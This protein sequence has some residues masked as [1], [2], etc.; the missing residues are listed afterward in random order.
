MTQEE[1]L[2]T[3]SKEKRSLLFSVSKLTSRQGSISNFRWDVKK[4]YE[5]KGKGDQ[6]LRR[7]SLSCKRSGKQEEK[8]EKQEAK[9]KA[10]RPSSTV[11]CSVCFSTTRTQSLTCVS[12]TRKHLGKGFIWIFSSDVFFVLSVFEEKT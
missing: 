11:G 3:N 1:V 9:K 7:S 2:L 4:T 10:R 6:K 5:L 12:K 8:Q